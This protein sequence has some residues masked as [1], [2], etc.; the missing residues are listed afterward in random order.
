[1]SHARSLRVIGQSLEAARILT[2][3]LEK[4]GPQYMVWTDSVTEAGEAMLRNALRHNKAASQDARHPQANRVFCFSPADI[5]RLDA[6]AQKQRRNQSR[7]A[8]PR[9]KLLSHGLRTLGDHFDRMQVNAFRVEWTLGSVNIHYQRANEP[10]N[11]KTFTVEEVRE[12][13]AHPSLRRSGLYLF[14]PADA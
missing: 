5:S 7:S 9:A 11:C 4:Y 10:L 3:E 1:M 6:Q 12:L 2:F 14:P 13:C 8:T